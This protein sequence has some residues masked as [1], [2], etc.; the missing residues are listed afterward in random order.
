MRFKYSD[1]GITARTKCASC[2]MTAREIRKEYDDYAITDGSYSEKLEGWICFPCRESAES[3]PQG[4]VIVY[5][6]NEGIAE[7]YVVMEHEDTVFTSNPIENPEDLEKLEFED[8]DYGKSPIQFGYHRTDPWRGYYEPQAEGW[9][10]L[11]SDCILSYS[12]DAEE[13]KKFDVDIKRMLWELGYQFAVCFGTTSNVFSCGYDILVRKT[14]EPDIVKEMALYSSL[15]RL[16]MK[17]R[18]PER[19]R[20]TALTGKSEGFDEKD[21]LLAEASKRLEQGEDF[22]IVKED[23]LRKARES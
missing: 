12:R 21:K 14:E 19:F 18:D 1:Y 15:M 10:N 3:H 22:E 13:L 4:T 5:K 23:I 11:H 7:K 2:E 8:I 17:Y 6:P 16:S 20:M 9:K